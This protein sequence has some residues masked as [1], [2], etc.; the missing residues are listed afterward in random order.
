MQ[1]A[2]SKP[3]PRYSIAL[4]TAAALA[5][6]I[7]LMK[8]FS[9]VQWHHFA[10][11]VISLALLGYGVSGTFIALYRERL[12]SNFP[13][14]FVVNLFLF[15]ATSI[16]SFLLT[17]QIP[18]NAQEM[19][20]DLGG[21]LWLLA[22]FLL[23]ALPFFFVAN[24]V[25]LALSYFKAEVSRLYA[26][27]MIG[28]GI[29]SLSILILLFWL[30]PASILQAISSVGFLAA[31]LASYELG[32]KPK[33]AALLLLFVFLPF[34]LPGKFTELNMSPYKSLSRALQVKDTRI[35]EE[36]TSPLGL[37]TV[38]ESPAIPFRYAPGLSINS[39]TEPPAQLGVFTNGDGMSVIT[40]Y[41]DSIEGLEYLD[42]QTSALAYH[43]N[44]PES[45]LVIG[46]GGGSDVLQA[47]YNRAEHIDAVELDSQL[48]ALVKERYADYAGNIYARADVDIH[49][50][51][52]RG[53]ISGSKK[54]YDLIQLVLVDSFGAASA[55][56]YALSENY[57]YTVEAFRQYLRRLAP[58][59]YLS[60]SRW[61]KLPPRDSLKLFA[62]AI[63]ALRQEGIKAPGES[64]V[65]IRS[66]QTS[67]LLVRNGTFSHEEIK[68]LKAFCEE[69]N[70]DLAYYN[71]MQESEAN[72]FNILEEPYFYLGASAMVDPGQRDFPDR[73]RF[74]I[75][76]ATDDKP[77]FYHFF[78]WET[79]S[80][81]FSL[82]GAGGLYLMEWGYLILVVSLMLAL[83]ASVVLIL[84][85]LVSYQ[86][87]QAGS[88]AFGKTGTV[89]YFFAL[90][91]A[92]LFLEIAFMQR[93]ILYLSHP[94]YSAAIVLSSF[95]VFAGLG[96]GYSKHLIEKKGSSGAVRSAVLAIL[97]LGILYLLSLEKLFE[98]LIALPY[99]VKT[100]VAIL[101]IAPLAFAMGIPFPAGL[102]LLG[103]ESP[104]LIPWAWGVNG[105]AS[106][107]SAILATLFAIHFG[108]AAVTLLALL[109]YLAAWIVF[110][111]KKG[112]LR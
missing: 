44:R 29:G 22:Y 23:L 30:Y 14:A 74:D 93:F 45:L 4:V 64:L 87:V 68:S 92:F 50:A 83:F 104:S 16:S 55:G 105:C 108:F 41:P 25:G 11:M 47:I 103:K 73:Y 85:P 26:A 19:F 69:R 76:P 106:V 6:E 89:L 51:E 62:T 54:E 20:W 7:L 27:D 37:I 28:S 21:I 75:R 9:I 10:Y 82:Q 98:Y 67:T 12:L 43:L 32:I 8:L 66:W 3:I 1:K 56:L 42:Y 91:L 53:F 63:E 48:V 112:L 79:L 102:V 18:F 95:L 2:V 107:I 96:S 39:D 46:A 49:I 78:K 80:E 109:F 17:R 60:I 40:R 81:I 72:R 35:I 77:Y 97:V 5:Y 34:I 86:K 15:G 52:A 38:V 33:K 57:L 100:A 36:H 59:G 70:F 94:I 65:L 58:G 110:T 24:A 61:I 31:V 101:L 111:G 90:G 13:A 84:L 99:L 71:G 88:N